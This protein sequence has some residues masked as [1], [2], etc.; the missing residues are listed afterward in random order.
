MSATSINGRHGEPSEST[1]I[2]PRLIAQ[3]TKSFSTRSSRRR[4]D[5]PQAV[6]KRRL[7]ITMSVS[8]FASSSLCAD[9]RL[10]IGRDRIKRISLSSRGPVAIP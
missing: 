2:S 5:M 1:V 9:L 8:I 6:A 7:V 4:S 3:A 10:G